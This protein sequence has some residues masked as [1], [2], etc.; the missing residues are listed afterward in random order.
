MITSDGQKNRTVH[1]NTES[2]KVAPSLIQERWDM[3]DF[4]HEFFV[5]N[6]IAA[7]LCKEQQILFGNNMKYFDFIDGKHFVRDKARERR[8]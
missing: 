4:R 7:K 2:L 6:A 3:T 5:F 8:Y 1:T